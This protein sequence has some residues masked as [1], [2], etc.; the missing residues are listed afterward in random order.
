MRPA[1]PEWPVFRRTPRWIAWAAFV[2]VVGELTVAIE[3][4][5]VSILESLSALLSIL[6]VVAMKQAFARLPR[7]QVGLAL[8][9]L[10]GIMFLIHWVSAHDPQELFLFDFVLPL[11]VTA[12]FCSIWTR[13][14][15]IVPPCAQSLHARRP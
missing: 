6:W 9:I 2:A 14:R 7:V 3:L 13:K 15:Y 5:H 10:V 12:M 4:Q 1:L 11:G 8:W